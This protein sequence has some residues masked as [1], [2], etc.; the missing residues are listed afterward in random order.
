MSLLG[1]ASGR[2][3][4]TLLKDDN[5]DDWAFKMK[6]LLLSSGCRGVTYPTKELAQEHDDKAY[7]LLVRSVSDKYLHVIRRIKLYNIHC[8]NYIHCIHSISCIHCNHC[9]HRMHTVCALYNIYAARTV[10]T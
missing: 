10:H 1:A 9:I 7:G 4:V 3:V 8:I 6:A 5:Y 2:Y